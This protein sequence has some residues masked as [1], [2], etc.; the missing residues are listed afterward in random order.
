MRATL[1]LLL[2]APHLLA[3]GHADAT[4]DAGSDA[5]LLDDAGPPDAGPTVDPTAA[6]FEAL[7][8]DGEGP[9]GLWGYQVAVLDGT[10]AV[11][12]GGTD[13]GPFGGTTYDAAW[14]VEVGEAALSATPLD[15]TGPA[16]RYCGCAAYD[17]LRERVVVHGGRDLETPAFAPETWELDLASETWTEVA[18]ATQAAGTLGCAMAWSPGAEAVFMFGGGNRSG[19]RAETHRYDPD[20]GEWRLVDAEGPLARYDGTLIASHDGETLLLFGGSYGAMGSAFYA[21]LWRFDPAAETW[22]EIPLPEGP[23]GR[24][25]PWMVRDP[26]RLGLYVGFGYDGAMQPLGDLWYLDLED[27]DTP[28]WTDLPQ[29]LDGPSYRGFA[30]AL[31]GGPD[32]LGVVFGGYS[33]SRP[34]TDAWRLTR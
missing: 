23:V 27:P 31:P 12:I 7:E 19:Y 16:P 28:A 10:R 34:V 9:W 4:E 8:T 20:A 6:R 11:V 33:T 14:L 32:A 26:E 21:D 29:P 13:A 1:V 5:A 30:R 17:P 3:C 18:S 22:T 24:R 15:A 25:I 2:L